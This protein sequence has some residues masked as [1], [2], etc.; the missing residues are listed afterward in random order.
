MRF[1]VFLNEERVLLTSVAALREVLVTKAYDFVKPEK[2]NML[3]RAL[4]GHGLLSAQGEEH[5]VQT[6]V[7]KD[8]QMS[9]ADSRADSEEGDV[10]C[11]CVQTH[12]RALPCVLYVCVSSSAMYTDHDQGQRRERALLPSPLLKRP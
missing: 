8:P 6:D 7:L 9:I 11:L 12:Q 4:L 1:R 2:P 3:F 10:A 5:Q